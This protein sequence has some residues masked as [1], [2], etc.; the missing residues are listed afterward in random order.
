VA[1]ALLAEWPAPQAPAQGRAAAEDRLVADRVAEDRAAEDRAG[2]TEAGTAAATAA[3]VINGFAREAAL[4]VALAVAGAA[5]AD[6]MVCRTEAGVTHCEAPLNHYRVTGIRKG[7]RTYFE[8]KGT[9]V[10]DDR[11]GRADHR[12]AAVKRLPQTL[13]H[14]L[15][16]C[17][18]G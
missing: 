13:S 15:R 8:D 10:D 9:P 1:A 4:F 14:V 11:G 12:H 6:P 3:V 17:C 2:A 7:N 16:G 5:H 18:D